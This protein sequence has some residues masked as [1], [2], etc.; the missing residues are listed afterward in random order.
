MRR[1]WPWVIAG[2][3]LAFIA[4][5]ISFGRPGESMAERAAAF[6]ARRAT[7][8][9]LGREDKA[10]GDS[11]RALLAVT[12]AP[13]LVL[14]AQERW[15]EDRVPL[16][17]SDP[18][19]AV[20]APDRAASLQ[21]QVAFWQSAILERPSVDELAATCVYQVPYAPCTVRA[22]GEVPGSGGALR[23]QAAGRFLA[24]RQGADADRL[25]QADEAAARSDP[26]VG[27]T[28]DLFAADP[29]GGWRMVLAMQGQPAERPE[30]IDTPAG[31]M[32][33]VKRDDPS[34]P[35]LYAVVDGRWRYLYQAA[36]MQALAAKAPA[37][38]CL[39]G[40]FYLDRWPWPAHLVPELSRLGLN[41]ATLTVDSAYFADGAK[42][43]LV[44]AT[45]GLQGDELVLRTATVDILSRASLWDRTFNRC[46]GAPR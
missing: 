24:E 32:L 29:A 41:P 26:M 17:G 21:Q 3:V 22:S 30:Q 4:W 40:A 25:L 38:T 20:S 28:I 23:Y 34:G 45:A 6:D 13:D 44:H 42:A 5:D 19:D 7:D 8:P 9:V 35:A 2:A 16:G 12:A 10:V 46:T 37:G 36:W 15:G 39:G 43:A 33:M 18:P 27:A 11:L 31:P 14:Q 1:R